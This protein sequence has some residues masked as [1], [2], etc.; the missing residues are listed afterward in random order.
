M[1]LNPAVRGRSGIEGVLQ[2]LQPNRIQPALAAGGA[3][4]VSPARPRAR[5]CFFHA[6]ADLAETRSRAAT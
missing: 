4:D 1:I 3:F 6:Y 2:S 5:H